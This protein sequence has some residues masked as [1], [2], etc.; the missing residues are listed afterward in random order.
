VYV[1]TGKQ[2]MRARA[3]LGEVRRDRGVLACLYMGRPE[4]IDGESY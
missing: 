2:L 4:T 1:K 3:I